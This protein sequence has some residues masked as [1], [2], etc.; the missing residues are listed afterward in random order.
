MEC[1]RLALV[2]ASEAS[3]RL[4]GSLLEC[5]AAAAGLS[6]ALI[7]W[8][9]YELSALLPPGGGAAAAA[10]LGQLAKE[11]AGGVA[12]AGKL[13]ALQAGQTARRLQPLQDTLGVMPNV[14]AALACRRRALVSRVTLEDDLAARRAA[15]SGLEAKG[16]AVPKAKRD[17]VTADCAALGVALEAARAEHG[18]I[19]ERNSSELIMFSARRAGML[20]EGM[21]ELALV[22]SIAET[23]RRGL[24]EEAAG[25]LGKMARAMTASSDA[26][27]LL[28][29]GCHARLPDRV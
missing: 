14:L 17:A 6:D 25:T 2:R 22:C 1:L 8:G 24:W 11:A 5:A 9:Q 16:A 4:V 28:P 26:M 19:T 13:S 29:P 27:V 21:Q 12:R 3:E 7:G 15:L 20:R 18:R 23:Q 10:A